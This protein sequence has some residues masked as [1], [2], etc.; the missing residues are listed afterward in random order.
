M[1]VQAREISGDQPSLCGSIAIDWLAL[2]KIPAALRS[3][4][5]PTQPGTHITTDALVQ[6]AVCCALMLLIKLIAQSQGAS[7]LRAIGVQRDI[8]LWSLDAAEMCHTAGFLARAFAC[9]EKYGKVSRAQ[10]SMHAAGPRSAST[11]LRRPTRI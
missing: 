5:F 9:F 4:K 7:P 3:V 2:L 1:R 11:S 8:E 10:P 6:H